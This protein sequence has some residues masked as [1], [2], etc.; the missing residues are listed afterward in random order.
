MKLNKLIN[1]IFLPVVGLTTFGIIGGVMLSSYLDYQVYYQENYP[2]IDPAD[3][4]KLLN[5]EASLKPEVKYYKNNLA[6]PKAED[7]LLIGTYLS[8]SDNKEF[9]QE[10]DP[11]KRPYKVSTDALFFLQGGNINISYKEFNL[12]IE[13]VELIDVDFVGI[14][15]SEAPYKVAYING[16]T[17]DKEGMVVSELYN[18]GTTKKL[19]SDQYTISNTNALTL[20]NTEIN[21]TYMKDDQEYVATQAITVSN[22]LDSSELTSIFPI[23]TFYINDGEM[24]NFDNY[25]FLAKYTSGNRKILPYSQYR[26]EGEETIA[27]L[28][29]KYSFDVISNVNEKITSKLDINVVKSINILEMNQVGGNF[30]KESEYVLANDTLTTVGSSYFVGGFGE[31]VKKGDEAKISFDINSYTQNVSFINLRCAN[32]FLRE[33][34]SLYYMNPLQINT[35]ADLYVNNEPVAISDEVILA[36][37]GPYKSYAPL[38]NVYSDFVI[39]NIPL[40]VGKNTISLQFKTSTVG[41]VNKWDESPSTLNIQ[42]IDVISSGK[43]NVH[44]GNIVS[45]DILDDFSILMGQYLRVGDIPVIATYED[46]TTELINNSLLNIDAPFGLIRD[47][48]INISISL[49]ENT[50]IA[51]SKTIVVNKEIYLEAEKAFKEGSNKVAD[52]ISMTY[53][54]DPLTNSFNQE[55]IATYVIGLDASTTGKTTKTSTKYSGNTSLTYKTY[56]PEGEYTLSTRCA[57]TYYWSDG[58]GPHTANIMLNDLISVFVNGTQINFSVNIPGVDSPSSADLPWATFFELDL[59]SVYLNEGYNTI[60]IKCNKSGSKNTNKEVSIPRFDYFKLELN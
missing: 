33:V 1:L 51:I 27:H 19:T 60:E 54:Y 4:A 18:D 20:D 22:S 29:K 31:A 49:K 55:G 26:I 12:V 14:E 52:D 47:D 7:I 59:A 40:N 34:D 23:E 57:N 25:R 46:E 13:N 38:Y 3:F 2:E 8:N 41:D 48:E 30:T 44:Q 6:R 58:V 21:V 15:I 11:I 17:F 10:I 16:E 35:I 24:I 39:P 53:S 50:A 32:S 37:C 36:G 42:S 56:V 43:N 28:G 5:V 45:I 9:T